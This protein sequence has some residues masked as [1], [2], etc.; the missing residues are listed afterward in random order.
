MKLIYSLII[1]LQLV[2]SVNADPLSKR[3]SVA[4]ENKT[5]QETIE[6]IAA[7]GKISFSYNSNILS[8]E[9]KVSLNE[10]NK[11]LSEI[12]S[13]LFS[14]S[15]ITFKAVGETIVLT[16]KSN[17]IK[18]EKFEGKIIDAETGEAV[19]YAGISFKGKGI[20]TVTNE[21]GLFILKFPNTMLE[22]EMTLSSVGYKQLTVKPT[23]NGVFKL[24][25]DTLELGTVMVYNVTPENIILR[26]IRAIPFNYDKKE[27]GYTAFYREILKL[28]DTEIEQ[29]E[30]VIDIVKAPYHQRSLSDRVKLVKGRQTDTS[31]DSLAVQLKILGGPAQ[32]LKLDIA[33]Y[34]PDFLQ[35]AGLK[36]YKFEFGEQLPYGNR[37]LLVIKFDQKDKVKASLFSGV[38]YIDSKSYAI[39]KADFGLSEKGLQYLHGGYAGITDKN[40]EMEYGFAIYRVQ[41]KQFN[42]I[43]YLL[44]AKSSVERQFSKGKNTEPFIYT[45][46]A[47]LIVTERKLKFDKIKSRDAFKSTYA[48]CD[49]LSKRTDDYWENHNYLK[50]DED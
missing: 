33:K 38:L 9:Q 19:P 50:S 5:L 4:V 34:P 16:P 43:W 8:N 21:S 6:L 22:D 48:L 1:G 30:A 14:G 45:S 17:E 2:L 36:N 13:K 11:M 23:Q 35:K 37:E 40:I 32:Y 10:T 18:Y 7:E 24:Q 3:I 26:V 29:N 31:P 39:V 47:E 20:G 25:R 44:S 28:K 49:E 46:T 42:D 15:N 41:Y 27:V 12:L